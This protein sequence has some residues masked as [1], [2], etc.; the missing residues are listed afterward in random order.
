[1]GKPLRSDQPIAQTRFAGLVSAING[2]L[3]LHTLDLTAIFKAT[4]VSL[5]WVAEN[6]M[7]TIKFS[8]QRSVDG[9]NYSDIGTKIVAGQVNTPTE[10]EFVNDIQNLT[11]YNV[12]YYRIKAED[13]I[14]RFA[15]SNIVSVRLSKITGIKIWPNPFLNDISLSYN[16]VA[17]GKVDVRI[18]DY[19]GK[20]VWESV[21]DIS[22]GINQ[23]SIKGL[24][25]LTA[26]YYL[27]NITDRATNQ[28]FVQRISK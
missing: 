8:I 2:T 15:Y 7:N 25:R 21:F 24:K 14:Q 6:E 18:M 13:N 10:Y 19:S 16:G 12:I 1:M 11:Q 5:R 3:P 27:V 28:S 9:A 23:L 26:G 17:N 22:R 20:V 4:K